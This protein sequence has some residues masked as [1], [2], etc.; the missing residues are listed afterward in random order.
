MD[1]TSVWTAE[2]MRNVIGAAAWAWVVPETR[3]AIKDVSILLDGVGPGSTRLLWLIC[4]APSTDREPLSRR[5]GY[6]SPIER[7]RIRRRCRSANYKVG[8]AYRN[9]EPRSIDDPDRA[10]CENQV[11]QQ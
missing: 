6:T 2:R 11:T 1:V 10:S 8:I 4:D 5:I 7:R 3:G 9:R